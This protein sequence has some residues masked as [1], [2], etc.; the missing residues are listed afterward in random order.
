[1]D[2]R[3]RWGERH[4][5]PNDGPTGPA[6]KPRWSEPVTWQEGLREASFVIPGGSAAAPAIV[7]T[8]C[9]VVGRAS[10]IMIEFFASPARVLA[11]LLLIAIVV[12]F[13]ARRTSWRR[14]DPLPVVERRRAG[15]IVRAAFR[16]YRRQP[17]AYVAIGLIGLPVGLAALLTSAVLGQLPWFGPAATVVE[18]GGPSGRLLVSSTIAAAFWP[19]AALLLTAAV[20]QML[21]RQRGVADSVRAV[22]RKLADL[23]SSFVPAVVAIVVLSLTVVGLPV[24]IWATVRLQ[25][26]S[27]A[28]MLDGVRG[29]RAIT[30]S[31]AL[32]RGRWLHTALVALLV[33][34]AV[35]ATAILIGLIVLVVA[36]SLPLWA[37]TTTVV[38]CEVALT[39]LG[40]I[41]MT[42]LYGDA[43][44]AERPTAPAAPRVMQSTAQPS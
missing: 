24:A 14:V 7:N 12:T 3:R 27:Q 22:W 13:L 21:G 28:T 23:A 34:S 17:V 20:A 2:G 31:G 30:R 6:L 42:L 11:G 36:T 1:M 8:F 19:V 5:S 4:P 37:V 32:V 18:G 25:F 26:L 10:T 16:L 15:E 39:P 9:D 35:H 33:W 38:A 41:C 29:W 43:A 40:A 44:A